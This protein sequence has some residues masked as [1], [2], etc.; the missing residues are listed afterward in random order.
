MSINIYVS[1]KSR[2]YESS[3]NNTWE[4]EQWQI[5]RPSWTYAHRN[6]LFTL[7]SKHLEIV[8]KWLLITTELELS[9]VR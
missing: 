7:L 6:D 3:S 5:G 8:R 2:N 1:P 9:L 4:I